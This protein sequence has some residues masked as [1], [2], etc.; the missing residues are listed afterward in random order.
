M[1]EVY[2][3]A[4]RNFGNACTSYVQILIFNIIF[5]NFGGFVIKKRYQLSVPIFLKITFCKVLRTIQVSTSVPRVTREIE[6]HKIYKK[7][8]TRFIYHSIQI[9]I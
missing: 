2:F 7:D 8:E 5:I 6:I 3:K 4:N 9:S 1:L